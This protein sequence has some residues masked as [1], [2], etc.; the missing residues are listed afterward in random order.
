MQLFTQRKPASGWSKLNK[1][2]VE[3]LIKEGLMTPAGMEK[4]NTA[5]EN[6]H[7]TKLDKIE[8]HEMPPEMEKAFKKNKAAKKHFDTLGPSTRKYMIHWISNAKLP[9]TR[10]KRLDELIPA[11]AEGKMPAHFIRPA[12]K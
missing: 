3:R 7:W 8:A 2:R 11:L 9:A 1:D 10:A 5:K 4:I 12:K 6:G